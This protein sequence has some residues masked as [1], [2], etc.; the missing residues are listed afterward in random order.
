VHT[1]TEHPIRRPTTTTHATTITTAP[2]STTHASTITTAPITTA[3]TTH[4]ASGS[5]DD[6]TPQLQLAGRW[7]LGTANAEA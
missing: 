4:V 7:L 6:A 2:I 3:S 5:S 1:H